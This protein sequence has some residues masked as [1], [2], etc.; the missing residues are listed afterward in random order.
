[1]DQLEQAELEVEALLLPVAQLVEGTEHDG[2]EAGELF[3]GEERGGAGGAVALF[4]RDLQQFAA[5]PVASASGVRP[6]TLATTV[7]RR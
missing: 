6:V 5:M 1:M 7:L 2:E 4:G 3:F